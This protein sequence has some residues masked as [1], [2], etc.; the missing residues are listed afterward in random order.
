MSAHNF[1]PPGHLL[2]FNKINQGLL[3]RHASAIANNLSTNINNLPAPRLA[4]GVVAG[5]DN[6]QVNSNISSTGIYWNILQRIAVPPYFEQICHISWHPKR[7]KAT[8]YSGLYHLKLDRSFSGENPDPTTNRVETA[9]TAKK[10]GG[11]KL[12][13]SLDAISH[14]AYTNLAPSSTSYKVGMEFVKIFNTYIT[15][16]ALTGGGNDLINGKITIQHLNG[17]TISFEF[18]ADI[19]PFYDINAQID[20]INCNYL[21]DNNL[22]QLKFNQIINHL[23]TFGINTEVIKNYVVMIISCMN[24]I[25]ENLEDLEDVES[26]AYSLLVTE[27][28][29]EQH[30]GEEQGQLMFAEAFKQ[31]YGVQIFEENEQ[32]T[33]TYNQ[34]LLQP[35]YMPVQKK[36]IKYKEKYLKIKNQL[37]QT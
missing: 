19:S 35:N 13:V 26:T 28:E 1:I 22:Y 21:Q 33:Y 16:N 31:M 14:P 10:P 17:N 3:K 37:N 15:S 4:P 27:Q 6:Y 30:Y 24:I 18:D 25:E 5:L 32:Q 23:S 9:I 8:Q 2:L 12:Q 11:G 20:Q 34:Q 7:P 29:Y 36:Y